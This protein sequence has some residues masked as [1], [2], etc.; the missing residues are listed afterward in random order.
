MASSF[1][2]IGKSKAKRGSWQVD[3]DEIDKNRMDWSSAVVIDSDNQ[4]SSR[5]AKY[6]MMKLVSSMQKPQ[7]YI[8]SMKTMM[9]P[10]LPNWQHK[11]DPCSN[12]TEK[13]IILQQC[14]VY[15]LH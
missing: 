13:R 5:E 4:D 15:L 9:N 1:S 3:H 12:P 14:S 7:Q 6:T 10:D 2:V 11:G 8:F